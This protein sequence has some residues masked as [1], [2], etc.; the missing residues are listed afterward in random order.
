MGYRGLVTHCDWLQHFRNAVP[1]NEVDV[2]SMHG[3]HAHPGDFDN[4]GS[5]ISQASSLADELSWWRGI[6][7]TRFLDRPFAITEYGHVYWN[8]YRYEEGLSI[9]G[10]GA[11]QDH[12]LIMAHAAPV[13]AQATPGIIRPFG[14]GNDPVARASQVISG[15]IFLRH[16]VSPAA[17][18]V[19]LEIRPEELFTPENISGALPREQSRIQL[20]TRFGITYTGSK[21]PAGVSGVKSDVKLLVSG[22]AKVVSTDWAASVLDGPEGKFSA[23]RFFSS[24][25]DKGLLPAANRTDVA[26]GCFEAENG[27]LFLDARNRCLTVRTPRTEGVC[28]A[29]FSGPPSPRIAHRA[30]VIQTRA[31]GCALPG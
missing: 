27:Q 30:V 11:F 24:L 17:H 2:I 14:V 15:L 22:S 1:R 13:R 20:V 4:R 28:D 7:G 21:P 9:G 12:D 18:T 25:K 19:H 10:Y 5:T 23:E 6:A 3:Y 8:R 29:L 26:K 31:G 16:D